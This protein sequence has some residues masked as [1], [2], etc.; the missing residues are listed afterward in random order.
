MISFFLVDVLDREGLTAQS[1]R[2]RDDRKAGIQQE[3]W[4]TFFLFLL[5]RVGRES[6]LSLLAPIE[7]V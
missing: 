5:D 7:R 4:E 3:G 1:Y 2:V 6:I